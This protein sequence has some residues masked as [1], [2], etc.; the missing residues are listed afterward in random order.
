[1]IVEWVD[2]WGMKKCTG[3]RCQEQGW[4]SD[5]LRYKAKGH[6]Y[7]WLRNRLVD[8]LNSYRLGFCLYEFAYYFSPLPVESCN[9]ADVTNFKKN[10]K[11]KGGDFTQVYV[12][13]NLSIV[14]TL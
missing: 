3:A 11:K 1:M 10:K 5:L 9:S 7:N 2:A 8:Q 14:F 4:W 6:N 12:K 13:L